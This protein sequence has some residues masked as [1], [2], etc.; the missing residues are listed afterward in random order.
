MAIRTG[1]KRR[2]KR[3]R[4]QATPLEYVIITMEDVLVSSVSTGGSGGE[5]RLTEN[6]LGLSFLS[7]TMI[8]T[9][10]VKTAHENNSR[11]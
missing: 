9:Y 8:A 1:R 6:A 4:R 2:K 11:K 5:D 3:S 10:N 7:N